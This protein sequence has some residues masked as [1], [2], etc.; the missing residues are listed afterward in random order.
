MPVTLNE[1]CKSHAS[2]LVH[3]GK[4]N[5]GSWAAPE[6]RNSENCI[7]H[8]AGAAGTKDEWKYPIIKDGEV[9]SKGV[10]SALAYAEKDAPALVAALKEIGKAIEEHGKSVAAPLAIVS[11][12]TKTAYGDCTGP[13]GFTMKSEIARLVDAAIKS[14]PR[15]LRDAFSTRM[16]VAGKTFDVAGYCRKGVVPENTTFAEGE[17]ADVSVIT[18]DSVDRDTDVVIPR[19]MD[20]SHFQKNMVVP[21]AHNY[22]ELPVGKCQWVALT[23]CGNGDGWK[24]KTLY[25]KRPDTHPAAAEWFPDSVWH[26]VKE[27]VLRGKSIGFIPLNYRGPTS[28]E[29]A[30]HSTWKDARI[31]DKCLALEYSVVPVPANQ[32]ALVESVA[33][34]KSYLLAKALNLIIPKDAQDDSDESVMGIACPAC[35]AKQNIHLVDKYHGEKPLYQC[36]VCGNFFHDESTTA[37]HIG[38]EPVKSFVSQNTIQEALERRMKALNIEDVAAAQIAE[39]LGKP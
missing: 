9:Y 6:E 24:A 28:D 16:T 33:K 7:G 35:K 17:H 32:D 19:G 11:L 18:S 3:T 30:M 34:S 31:L 5:H 22:D 13:L 15:E 12:P 4:I 38:N 36:G 39:I 23:K 37:D 29:L 20:W 21:F 2:G 26:N 10:G 25:T 8:D 14:Q 1:K 27:G